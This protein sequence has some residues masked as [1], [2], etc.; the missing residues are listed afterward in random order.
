MSLHLLLSER[1]PWLKVL[2]GI[3]SN[4]H[5]ITIT[6]GILGYRQ[7]WN[8]KIAMEM[9]IENK[10][11][12]VS[13]GD[14]SRYFELHI[15]SPRSYQTCKSTARGVTGLTVSKHFDI[16]FRS[17]FNVPST[18]NSPSMPHKRFSLQL[19]LWWILNEHLRRPLSPSRARARAPAAWPAG[20]PHNRQLPR[21]LLNLL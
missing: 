4:S 14:Y 18:K 7:I 2:G 11:G 10:T 1:T 5:V 3:H 9:S 19:K 21:P 17:F 6:S 13:W 12:I 8:W 16:I 20:T 15:M